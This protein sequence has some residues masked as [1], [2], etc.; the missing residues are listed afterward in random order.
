MKLKRSFGYPKAKKVEG[1][2]LVFDGSWLLIHRWIKLANTLFMSWSHML[3]SGLS[4]T[5]KLSATYGGAALISLGLVGK[6][7][8]KNN[9]LKIIFMSWLSTTSVK[10]SL[11]SA[12][13]N[14]KNRF[15]LDSTSGYMLHWHIHTSRESTAVSL[16]R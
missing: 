8:H 6:I 14:R 2:I 11:H 16:L 7:R 4:Y 1:M 15:N 3:T 13:I 12:K 10:K 9:G 5:W